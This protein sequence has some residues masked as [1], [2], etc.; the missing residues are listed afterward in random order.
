[1][2]PAEHIV[3][4]GFVYEFLLQEQFKDTSAEKL[5]HVLKAPE[6]KIE[7]CTLRI[8]PTFQYDSVEMRI[9]SQNIPKRLVCDDQCSVQFSTSSFGVELPND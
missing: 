1:M 2:L 4:E 6:R 9:P 7:K 3:G 5:S 8:E